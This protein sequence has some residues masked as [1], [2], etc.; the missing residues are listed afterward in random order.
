MQTSSNKEKAKATGS[1]DNA[2]VIDQSRKVNND[3][4]QHQGAKR[5]MVSFNENNKQLHKGMANITNS[6]TSIN[7]RITKVDE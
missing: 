5:R 3:N 1:N 7:N 6:L 2:M 4:R